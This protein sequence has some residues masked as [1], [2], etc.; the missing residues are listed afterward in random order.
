MWVEAELHGDSRWPI[1]LECEYA[2]N[3]AARG[4]GADERDALYLGAAVGRR[5]HAGD[6]RFGVDYA[7]VEQEAVLAAVNRG[8]YATNYEGTRL[9]T[10]YCP[11]DNVEW[12]L[13]YTMSHNLKDI[14][15]G[16]AFDDRQLRLYVSYSW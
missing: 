15:R 12:R 10:R 4:E 2:C 1:G 16:F 5:G 8:E 7:A 6:W 11:L 13:T 3:L 14:E 9:E